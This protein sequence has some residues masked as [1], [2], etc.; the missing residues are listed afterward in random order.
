MPGQQ[1]A[2]SKMVRHSVDKLQDRPRNQG[3]HNLGERVFDAVQCAQSDWHSELQ[4]NSVAV[5]DQRLVRSLL[6]VLGNRAG[7]Q[8]E[9]FEIAFREDVPNLLQT[10]VVARFRLRVWLR[11][12]KTL[13]A[14]YHPVGVHFPNRSPQSEAVQVGIELV[15]ASFA[16]TN[17][18]FNQG[19]WRLG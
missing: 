9:A 1:F 15:R 2:L 17:K 12:P 19:S 8:L 14:A 10:A 18:P 5:A 13:V 11:P 16:R 6:Q 4:V 7:T 3:I